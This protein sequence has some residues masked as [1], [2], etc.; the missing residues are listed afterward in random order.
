MGVMG[1]MKNKNLIPFILLF[2]LSLVRCPVA[3]AEDEF[4]MISQSICDGERN[5]SINPVL[6]FEFNHRLDP[7]DNKF[8]LNGSTELISGHKINGTTLNIYLAH[9]LEY[10]RIYTLSLE[11]VND[12]YSNPS[13]IGN[14]TF[15]TMAENDYPG[16]SDDFEEGID[17]VKEKWYTNTFG[18]SGYGIIT[19]ETD[20]A[21]FS[22]KALKLDANTAQARIENP[23]SDKNGDG[24]D[25]FCLPGKA[26]ID[27][28]FMFESAEDLISTV[29][30]VHMYTKEKLSSQ[31]SVSNTSLIHFVPQKDNAKGK[32]LFADGSSYADSGFLFEYK[33]WH[34]ITLSVDL[35]SDTFNAYIDGIAITDGETDKIFNLKNPTGNSNLI[36]NLQFK[37]NTVV[38]GVGAKMWIDDLS[39][40]P[41][42]RIY[43]MCFK[44]SDGSVISD[45]D[46]KLTSFSLKIENENPV[47]NENYTLVGAVYDK[48]GKMIGS[49]IIELLLL[50]S[51][52]KAVSINFETLPDGSSIKIFLRRNKDSIL[53]ISNISET[54]VVGIP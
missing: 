28:R 24:I 7:C 22:N 6:C 21:D 30:F 40:S 33:S 35:Y 52:A 45:I 49:K 15:S 16:L 19:V 13:P 39:V 54:S 36:Y 23:K 29:S 8:T 9:E 25:D 41:A 32:V 2:I 11:T 17:A 43:D 37:N 14:I 12:L 44:G 31:N 50:P 5:V 10:S 1:D 20:P 26:V 34:R 42:L 3:E 4:K 46:S 27:F 53:E 38:N 48:N 18:Y 47:G 51:E